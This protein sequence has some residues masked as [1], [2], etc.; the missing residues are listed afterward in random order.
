MSKKGKCEVHRLGTI[1]FL[2][3]R[4]V[5]EHMAIEVGAGKRP[6]ALFLLEHPHTFTFGRRGKSGNL[7]WDE[8]EL[9][10]RQ[11]EVHWTDRGGDATYHGPGQLVGYP[12]IPLG[13][14]ESDNRLPIG[15]FIGYLRDLERVLIRALATLGLATGQR[16]GQTGVW[17]Q[18]D[19]ASRCKHC[20]PAARKNPSK[21]ASIGVR[22]TAQ[23]VS[24]HGFALNVA[25]DMQ[26]W[27]GIV[28][29]DLPD[30]PM[31]SLADLLDPAPTIEQVA[32]AVVSE[33][34][35]VFQLQ[36]VEAIAA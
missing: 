36:M 18:P 7:L 33:F 20:P 14:L 32:E 19:V 17:V 16:K 9:T 35:R 4:A 6:G 26:Y 29:C 5:Q 30:A 31:V 21:L 23:G 24:Q 15:D 22:V 34:G 10:D 28:A 13:R 2:S 8:G 25:P 11:V 1:D 27:E 12:V 3:A